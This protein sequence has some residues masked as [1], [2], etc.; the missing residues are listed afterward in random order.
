[1]LNLQKQDSPFGP[2][3]FINPS[4]FTRRVHPL[5]GK[6]S[7]SRRCPLWINKLRIH[8][9]GSP[10]SGEMLKSIF[11]NQDALF[12]LI[13]PS[14]FTKQV[15]PCSI[16]KNR[17]LIRINKLLQVHQKQVYPLV[18]EILN[19]RT[20]MP[21]RRPLPNLHGSVSRTRMTPS[22]LMSPPTEPNSQCYPL[23]GKCLI[24]RT[25]RRPSDE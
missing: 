23:V 4:K 14:K 10:F 17:M 3:K 9:A 20:R 5:V 15:G 11:Q 18:R 22:E 25:R 7:I 13:N 2:L 16:F 6:C 19:S 12:G 21:L 24:S 1:M 8:Q